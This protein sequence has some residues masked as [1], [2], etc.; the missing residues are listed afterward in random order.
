MEVEECRC[1]EETG[2]IGNFNGSISD[3]SS[4]PSFKDSFI[5]L[6]PVAGLG[7]CRSD[8]V[9]DGTFYPCVFF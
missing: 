4:E 1:I 6:F 9:R 3:H 2:V 5:E 7:W 8:P